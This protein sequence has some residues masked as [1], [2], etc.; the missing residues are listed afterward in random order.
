M[1]YRNGKVALMHLFSIA[2]LFS[3]FLAAD[4]SFTIYRLN[5]QSPVNITFSLFTLSFAL[6]CFCIANSSSASSYELCRFWY[7][8]NI[9]FGIFLPGMALHFSM[10]FARKNRIAKSPPVVFAVYFLPVFFIIGMLFFGYFNADFK[11]TSWG[12][13][14]DIDY[15]SGYNWVFALLYSLPN[16]LSVYYVYLWRRKAENE[17][18][19]KQASVLILPYISGMIAIIV[20]PYFFYIEESEFLNF[21]LNMFSIAAFL[22]FLAGTRRAVKKYNF[23]KI[24]PESRID[25]LIKGIAEPAMITDTEGNVICYNKSAL[26]FVRDRVKRYISNIFTFELVPAALKDELKKMLEVK[27]PEAEITY[28]NLE[29]YELKKKYTVTIKKIIINDNETAGLLWLLKEDRN[30]TSFIDKFYITRRQMDIINL[31]LSGSSNREI[32]A[33]LG[34]SERTVENHIF[35]IYNKIGVDNRIELFNTA[36][37]Y[38]II[39]N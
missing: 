22:Y 13:D 11:H 27:D 32:S 3:S 17:Y 19:I 30:I 5:R 18:E 15:F 20:N 7:R 29:D 10:F 35:N 24:K 33:K 28:R 14:S 21:L 38:G 6:S 31:V 25:I 4:S 8:M 36:V 39:S 2:C 26:T 12:W 37:S 23:L 1:K 9:P 34:I 16:L